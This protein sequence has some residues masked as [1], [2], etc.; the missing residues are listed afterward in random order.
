VQYGTALGVIKAAVEQGKRIS[1][2]ADETRPLLQGARLTTWE[3]KALKIPVTLIT[4]SMAGFF[5]SKHMIDCVIAG[6]DR[7]ALNGDTANKI[8]TYSLAVLARANNIPFYI[9]APVSSIDFTIKTGSQIIIEERDEKEV[10]QIRGIPIAPPGIKAAN[11]SFDITPAKYINAI[12][13]DNG[14]VKP[15]FRRSILNLREEG[16]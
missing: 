6:A 3:L 16:N 5:M 7:I 2:Y 1:V 12:I 15:P 14:I 11:P 9:A 8:G 13:T 4:D 10:L